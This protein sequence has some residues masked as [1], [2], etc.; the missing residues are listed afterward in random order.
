MFTVESADQ[1]FLLRLV[2]PAWMNRSDGHVASL[3][4]VHK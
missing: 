4:G 2:I 3:F 1:P